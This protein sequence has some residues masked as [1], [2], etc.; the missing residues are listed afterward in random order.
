MRQVVR[1]TENNLNKLVK[2]I[3]LEQK[4]KLLRSLLGSTDN[5]IK[6]FGERYADDV[7]SLLTKCFVNSKNLGLNDIG[8]QALISSKGSKLSTAAL[9]NILKGLKD[10]TIDKKM[11]D[12]LPEYLADM[13]PFREQV[14]NI[15]N[16]PGPS[17][18]TSVVGNVRNNMTPYNP[19]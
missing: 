9:M 1:L 4:H 3:I 12:R 15:V 5:F 10:G 11:I 2:K 19:Y 6:E 13:T 8:E 17:S 7:E 18:K 14:R 16:S